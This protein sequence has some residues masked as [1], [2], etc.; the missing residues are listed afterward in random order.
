MDLPFQKDWSTRSQFS[1]K[2]SANLNPVGRCHTVQGRHLDRGSA[3]TFNQSSCQAVNRIST[4]KATTSLEKRTY[5]ASSRYITF[6]SLHCSASQAAQPSTNPV[7][8]WTR[9]RNLPNAIPV[10]LASNLKGAQL[11]VHIQLP[12]TWCS[13]KAPSL[14]VR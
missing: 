1:F 13:S 14:K 9:G 6:P 2:I 3:K 5:G 12:R 11:T 7:T 4:A 8:E 10:A